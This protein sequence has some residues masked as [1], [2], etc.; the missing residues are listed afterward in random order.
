MKNIFIIYRSMFTPQGEVHTIGG[1]ENYIISLIETFHAQGWKTHIVQPAKVNFINEQ[2][3]YTINGVNTGLYRGNSKKFALAKWVKQHATSGDIVIF[4]TDSYAVKIKSLTTIGIQHGI[5][6]DKPK[7]NDSL[8]AQWFSSLLNQYKYLQSARKSDALVCVDHNFV[9]WYRT[10]ITP[11]NQYIKVIY[12]FF[13]QKLS[14]EQLNIKWA[15]TPQPIKIIVARRF[16]DYR[17]IK[18]IAPVIDKLLNQFSNIEVTF[19]GEGP[20]KPLL[21]QTFSA[22]KRVTITQYQ[23]NES[24]SVHQQHH[25]ALIPTLGSE[26]TSL[27]MIEAMAAGCLVISSNVGGLSNLIID[28]FNGH[29]VMPNA[30]EFENTISH[31]IC[32]MSH[33]QAL[34]SRGHESIEQICSQQQWSNAWVGTIETLSN[35]KMSNDCD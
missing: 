8:V 1:I 17:G 22:D 24:Y 16:V 28:G 3:G 14:T 5:S 25:I 15:K 4:A 19:A 21:E 35:Q 33:S 10:W 13:Q 23:A 27:S 34:A 12:N 11:K 20:L 7:Q 9:N 30:D 32:N 6:W 18:M 29:L 2:S 26:G 31:A